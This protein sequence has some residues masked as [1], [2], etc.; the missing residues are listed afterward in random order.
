MNV[1]NANTR[2]CGTIEYPSLACGGVLSL[3]ASM[4]NGEATFEEAYS[5][6]PGT[7][8]PAGQIRATCQGR[9]MHW[10]WFGEGGPVSTTL[11]R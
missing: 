8:A 9:S 4:A 5:H 11:T 2:L 10:E 1:I 6:N 3:C 7:C